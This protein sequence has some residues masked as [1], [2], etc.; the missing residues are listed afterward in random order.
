V[1]HH[2][3]TA[4]LYMDFGTNVARILRVMALVLSVN[5]GFGVCQDSSRS[6]TADP[7]Q[8]HYEAALDLQSA[9]DFKRAEQE[10][11]AFLSSALQ[12]LASHRAGVED[13]D[14]ALALYK[15]SLGLSPADNG[16]R[17]DYAELC[18]RSG[19]RNEAKTAAEQ[20]ANEEPKNAAAHF[21]LGRI[22]LQ[23]DEADLAKREFETAVR[24]DP[25][26]KNGYGLASAYLKLREPNHA[27]RIF[28]EME[29]GFGDTA[30]IHMEFG[31]AYAES[32]Y[33]ELA[34]EEFKK[35]IA[36]DDKLQGAHYSLG[37][38]YLVGLSEAGYPQAADEFRIELNNHPDNVLSLLQLGSIEVS[39]HNFEIAEKL[40]SHAAMLDPRNPDIYLELGQVYVGENHQSEAEAAFRKSIALTSD[41]SRNHYQV[42]RA[43]YQLGRLLAQ[44]GHQ[45]EAKEELKI[46]DQLLKESVV[47]NQGRDAGTTNRAPVSLQPGSKSFAAESLDPEAIKSVEDYEAR[48]GPAVADAYNNLG[49]IAAGESSFLTA[50]DYFRHASAWNP[51]LE[52]VDV[53]FGRSSFSAGLFSW[54]VA[55]LTRA[56]EKHPDD[57]RTRLALGVSLFRMERYKEAADVLRPFESASDVEPRLESVYGICLLRSGRIEDGLKHLEQLAQR[58]P[59]LADVHAALGE[60]FAARGEH[61]KAAEQFRLATE[62]NPADTDAKHRYALSLIALQQT[63][64]AVSLLEDVIH[65]GVKQG[66]AYYELGNL[67]LKAGDVHKAISTWESGIAAD[68]DNASLHCGLEEAYRQSYRK[69]DAKSEAEKCNDLEKRHAVANCPSKPQ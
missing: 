34:V 39:R 13:F 44:T 15:Q 28:S 24:L 56:L 11:R 26:F 16:I 12:R 18:L 55:P 37:A 30:P 22:G 52:D 17:L 42:Q 27:G 3:T 33:P 19:D 68:P 53:N 61:L 31:R 23:M 2:F 65:S 29:T 62:L 9:G 6:N 49:V 64:E 43:H 69:E 8:Q 59:E 1:Q 32:G 47:S 54:A 41:V 51:S 58:V 7:L 66:D 40:L 46:S 10:Y 45:D 25:T 5:A 35:A 36:L 20:V 67:Q 60:G 63:R 14:K 38:A 21:L 50:A 48:I 57:R 4:L